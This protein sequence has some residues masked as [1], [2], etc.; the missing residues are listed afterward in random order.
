M[1]H[2]GPFNP[3]Y[4]K[5]CSEEHRALLSLIHSGKTISP[6]QRE[7]ISKA[8]KGKKKSHV[9][10]EAMRTSMRKRFIENPNQK[11]FQILGDTNRKTW[12]VKNPN[13]EI[14]TVSSLKALCEKHGL[15]YTTL[16][17]AYRKNRPVFSGR[18]AGWQLIS[19]S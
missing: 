12:E 19:S 17:S 18:S 13:G 3:F 1:C 10:T 15:N 9:T 5:K 14:F 6:E 11:M 2:A 4:G 8:L 7:M 16:L